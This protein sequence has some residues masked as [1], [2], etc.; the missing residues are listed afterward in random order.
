MIAC[1]RQL[2][3]CAHD[4]GAGEVL[5]FTALFVQHNF[6][7]VFIV[8]INN[9]FGEFCI[10]LLRVRFFAEIPYV[11]IVGAIFGGYSTGEIGN[12]LVA[13][14][15]IVGEADST[16]GKP[17]IVEH[18]EIFVALPFIFEAEA[19]GGEGGAGSF[20]AATHGEGHCHRFAGGHVAVSAGEILV[21]AT[22]KPHEKCSHHSCVFYSYF[23]CIVF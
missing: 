10:R 3:F 14:V 11:E 13:F 2:G 4:I 18:N 23:H 19:F 15:D 16:D 17:L 21:R 6:N 1:Y 22:G 20:G 7:N 8:S 5:K 9:A 12:F